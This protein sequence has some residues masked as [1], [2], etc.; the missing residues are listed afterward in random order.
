MGQ[1]L[2]FHHA[3]LPDGRLH[4]QHG[5]IDLIIGADGARGVALA[6]ALAAFE[7]VLEGLVAELGLLKTGG[8]RGETPPYGVQSPVAERMVSA[9]AR[10]QGFVTP[11]AAVA[12][13][14][15]DH[16]L[17]AMSPVKG[18]R[19]AYVNNGGDIALHLGAGEVFRLAMAGLDGSGLGAVE[20]GAGDAIGG[21]ATSG[22]G[23]RSLSLGIA[24]SVTVL[25]RDAAAAD[26][27]ATLIGNAVDLPGHC[28]IERVPAEEVQD[29][30]DLGARLVVRRV[31]PLTADEVSRALA[32][33]VKLAEDMKRNRLIDAA[34]LFL[35]GQNRVVGQ[36]AGTQQRKV[37]HA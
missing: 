24:E 37:E 2:S 29:D 21:V 11:M 3:I 4:V 19:R 14:V 33:G 30:S 35:R 10:H 36:M 31:G 20:I 32:R 15:A 1:Q 25:A 23:G 12:G 16:V 27:A 13:A 28:A 18:L 17:A 9:V 26:V 6:A 7:G 8:W 5:P 34:A 22:Q